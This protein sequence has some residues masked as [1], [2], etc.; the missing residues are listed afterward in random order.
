M[1]K[2]S[3]I[4]RYT[5][6]ATIALSYLSV[7]HGWWVLGGRRKVVWCLMNN[8]LQF[9]S[10]TLAEAVSRRQHYS[11]KRV[12]VWYHIGTHNCIELEPSM[13]TTARCD[14][15][16]YALTLH[17]YTHSLHY[18]IHTHCNTT[19]HIHTHCAIPVTYLYTLGVHALALSVRVLSSSPPLST[20]SS[21]QSW[22]DTCVSGV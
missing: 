18:H 13:K 12:K 16:Y 8:E 6:E 15:T 3:E 7:L 17:P 2:T 4:A 21:C 19:Y 5:W 22:E 14:L 11:S 9:V 1:L 20:S 10:K